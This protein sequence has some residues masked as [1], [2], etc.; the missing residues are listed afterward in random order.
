MLS[1]PDTRRGTFTSML[2]AGVLLACTRNLGSPPESPGG[3]YDGV[4]EL[5]VRSTTP[6][7]VKRA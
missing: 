3:L 2:P 1:D 7:S 6:E 4:V 5:E